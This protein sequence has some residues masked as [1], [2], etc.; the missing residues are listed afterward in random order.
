[1]ICDSLGKSAG[2]LSHISLSVNADM[3]EV[4]MCRY[5]MIGFFLTPT[6]LSLVRV[7]GHTIQKEL[8]CKEYKLSQDV[9]TSLSR[10]FTLPK[11]LNKQKHLY[12]LAAK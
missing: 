5:H 9:S 6:T 1:M 10:V 3:M 8:S 4:M 7:Q 2:G 12:P 11:Q